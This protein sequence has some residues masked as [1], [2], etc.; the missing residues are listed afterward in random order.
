[1]VSC[2]TTSI[3]GKLPVEI[4]LL[5]HDRALRWVTNEGYQNNDALL[6][7]CFPKT[8]DYYIRVFSFTYSQ[9]GGRLFLPLTVSTAPWIDAVFPPCVEPGKEARVTVYG[10]NLP[11]G[12]ADPVSMHD[13]RILEKAVV[14]VQAPTERDQRA[15]RSYLRRYPRPSTVFPSL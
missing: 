11:G 13:G 10:R 4:A 1:V 6:I 12:V 8:A 3:D 15:V 5:Q 14:T 9:G 7:P 2:L